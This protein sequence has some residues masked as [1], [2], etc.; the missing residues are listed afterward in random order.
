[1]M[2]KLA[3]VLAVLLAFALTGCSGSD[4]IA[5]TTGSPTTPTASGTGTVSPAAVAPTL[6]PRGLIPKQIGEVAG[7]GPG[8]KLKTAVVTFTVDK[9][10]LDPVCEARFA[11]KPE[12]GS[13][14]RVDLTIRTAANYVHSD[15]LFD[16]G[17]IYWSM[18]GDVDGLTQTEMASMASYSCLPNDSEFPILTSL[19]PSSTYK[20]SIVLDTKYRTGELMFKPINFIT[21]DG[22][23]WEW[24]VN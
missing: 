19:N 2:R 10:T 18:Q 3:F 8:G 9:I 16:A 7:I 11:E 1:M 23:G 22:G 12:Y 6:S 21:L 20:G 13:F 24:R 14:L 15:V 5:P 17:R 4:S